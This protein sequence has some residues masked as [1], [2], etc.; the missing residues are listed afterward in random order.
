MDHVRLGNTG[1]VVSRLA[2]GAMTFGAGKIPSVYKVDEAT[3]RVLVERALHAGINFFDTADAYA[4]GQSDRMLGQILGK[5]RKDVVISTKVGMRLGESVLS[6]GLS[7]QHILVSCDAS[8]TRLGTDYVDLYIVHRFDPVTPIEET[9]EALNDLVR[10]GRHPSLRQGRG[11][12][13]RR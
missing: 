11:V 13:P 1:L 3:A 5:R 9:L 8:V 7:R 10:A 4:D 2:L 6:T 12:P